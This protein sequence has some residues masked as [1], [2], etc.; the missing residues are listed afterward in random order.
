MV[1]CGRLKLRIIPA[2]EV[3]STVEKER[4]SV[5]LKRRRR[6]RCINVDKDKVVKVDGTKASISLFNTASVNLGELDI[7]LVRLIKTFT[8]RSMAYKMHCDE[9]YCSICSYSF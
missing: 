4:R 5:G 6:V 7:E 1:S 3:S 8:I 9:I 2:L